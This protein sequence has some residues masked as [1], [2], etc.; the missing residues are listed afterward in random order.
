MIKK[1]LM[2]GLEEGSIAKEELYGLDDPGLFAL[3]SGRAAESHGLF[4]LAEKVRD[5]RFYTAAAE[6]P[7]EEEH[8]PL[9]DIANRS[10][11][12]K[13]L[14][15]EIS[16]NLGIPLVPEELIID[17]PEPISFETGLYIRDEE[18]W[19]SESPGIFKDKD[20]FIK[21][22]R[23]IRIFMDPQREK[24]LKPGALDEILYIR[25]KWLQLI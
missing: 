15:R 21:S 9:L 4:S 10:R 17:I 3:M 25:K 1:A 5:G 2:G 6:F 19:F 24:N 13:V 20:A 11:H 8:R 14:A 16:E 7:F 22:L 18:R 23:I 12:E